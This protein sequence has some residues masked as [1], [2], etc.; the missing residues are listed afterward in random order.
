MN[1]QQTKHFI[2]NFDF[3]DAWLEKLPA[4]FNEISKIGLT[5]QEWHIMDAIKIA[6]M[7]SSKEGKRD[8]ASSVAKVLTFVVILV[9]GLSGLVSIAGNSG[10]EFTQTAQAAGVQIDEII[11]STVSAMLK[12]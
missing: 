9:F 12:K 10:F 11:Q 6:W 7:V 3:S 2:N 4:D 5:R 1:A 8:L